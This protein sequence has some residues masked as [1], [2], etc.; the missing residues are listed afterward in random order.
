[1][2]LA[3]KLWK[4]G[5]VLTK[6]D[7]ETT[8]RT[9]AGFKE[10]V[11]PVYLNI[12]FKF[13]NNSISNVVLDKNPVALNK[14]FFTKKTGGS[15]TGIYYLYPNLALQNEKPNKKIGQLKNTLNSSVLLF[16]C[17]TKK[18]K[19][20]AIVNCLEIDNSK[21]E[22]ILNQ[23]NN[24]S[25]DNYIICFSIN[26]KT[27][28]EEM[29]E[30]WENYNNNPF[31]KTETKLGIDIFTNIETEIGYNPSFAS[32][33]YDQYHASLN[34]RL[35]EN[36]SLSK[37]SARNIK[38]AWMFILKNMI[39]YYKGLE[40]VIIPN[41]LNDDEEMLRTVIHR[42][43]MANKRLKNKKT[44]LAEL[45]Q[46]EKIL[47]REIKRLHRGRVGSA[48]VETKLNEIN[49][50]I[51]KT[52]LGMFKE[53]NEQ[54]QT[55]DELIHSV[56]LDYI[57]TNI[58]RTNL[59]FDIN[60]TIEDVIPSKMSEVVVKMREYKIEDLVKL[61]AKNR[62]R[63]YLK[64]YFNRRELYFAL[65][66]NS[67]KNSNSI[68]TERLYLARLLLSDVKIKHSDLL[69]RF[70]FNRNYG[71]DKKKRMTKEGFQEWIQYPSGFAKDEDNLLQ[72]LQ[73]LN[74]IQED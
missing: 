51:E 68:N 55:L 12:N 41:L 37:D 65:N 53:F 21:F 44:I 70:E 20:E 30:V 63:T 48:E 29:P 39:F 47:S 42:F 56:T 8:V 67:S 17:E 15:G 24:L 38:Y 62:E 32:F 69:Q 19:I 57:F 40:Y 18:K 23:V 61:G 72:F 45:R 52:D 6:E 31:P 35:D 43:V 54:S 46:Q 5:S 26:G 50:K 4:I 14:L 28:Y 58:N 34:Y 60:G 74:K 25:K 7:I 11:E 49:T 33:S 10:G 73:S 16:C 36:L 2:S 3:H 9:D 27:F 59:S 64:D 13:E 22:S 66:G 71:Y 1:M